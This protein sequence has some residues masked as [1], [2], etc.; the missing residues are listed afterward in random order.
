MKSIDFQISCGV[1]SC[2]LLNTGKNAATAPVSI[3]VFLRPALRKGAG[4]S[5]EYI[6]YLELLSFLQCSTARHF[7]ESFEQE[8]NDMKTQV[9]AASTYVHPH[10]LLQQTIDKLQFLCSC[11]MFTDIDHGH[12]AMTDQTRDGLYYTLSDYAD[13]LKYVHHQLENLEAKP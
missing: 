5:R 13:T 11:I 6:E 2:Y 9:I 8:K 4:L 1:S 3:A 7:A 10:D 12:L